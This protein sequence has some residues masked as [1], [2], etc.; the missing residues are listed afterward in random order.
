MSER[1]ANIAFGR[2]RDECD[3]GSALQLLG[4]CKRLTGVSL[5]C[6]LKQLFGVDSRSLKEKANRAVCRMKT[7]VRHCRFVT[8]S[9]GVT[10]MA[11]VVVRD[12][13]QIDHRKQNKDEGLQEE[14]QQSERHQQNRQAEGSAQLFAS[15]K[16]FASPRTRSLLG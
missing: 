16:R 7:L 13:A 8:V 2:L 10:V 5:R 3:A 11:V 9:V 14:G 1:L 12:F 6:Y 15:A 4:E